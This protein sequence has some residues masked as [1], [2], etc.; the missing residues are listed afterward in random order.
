MTHR[1]LEQVIHKVVKDLGGP[2]FEAKQR[3]D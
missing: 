1:E 3:K 2:D